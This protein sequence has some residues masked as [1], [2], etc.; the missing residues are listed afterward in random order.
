MQISD[1]N[2]IIDILN[3]YNEQ[4]SLVSFDVFDTL[5]RRDISPPERVKIPALKKLRELLKENDIKISIEQLLKTRKKIELNIGNNLL[6]RGFDWDCPIKQVMECML[7]E[8]QIKGD[9]KNLTNELISVE[10][11]AEESI[12]YPEPGM[13]EIVKH[14][15]RLKK[16]LIWISD[17]YL[18]KVHITSLL[19]KCGY[20]NFFYDGYVSSEVKKRKKTGRLY[21]FVLNRL[22]VAPSEWLHFGDNREADYLIP[23][24]LG[25]KSYHYWPHNHEKY[26][27]KINKFE[28]LSK[29]RPYW[30]GSSVMAILQKKFDEKYKKKRL[31]NLAY[32]SGFNLLAPLFIN[33]IHHV[34]ERVNNE[35]IELVLFPAREGFILQNIFEK[36][37]PYLAKNQNITST[38]CYLTRK[39]TFNA[40]IENIGKRELK[41]GFAHTN[42][43]SIKIMLNRF[44]IP[45]DSIKK[46]L[47]DCNIS[48]IERVIK[49]P[50]N[51][52]EVQKLINNKD[53]L[54]IINKNSFK[55]KTILEKYLDQLNFWQSKKVAIVDV[56][57]QGTVQDALTRTFAGHKDW[58]HL[59][60]LYMSFLGSDHHMENTFSTYEGLLY[61][62]RQEIYHNIAFFKFIQLFEIATRAPHGTAI[63]L[64]EDDKTKKIIP[65][66][67]SEDDK[68]RL[69]ELEDNLLITSIQAGI[70]DCVSEIEKIIPFLHGS[71]SQFTPFVIRNINR[72]IQLPTFKEGLLFN[73][74]V[75]IEDFGN[76][77][78]LKN[79]Q[80]RLCSLKNPNI[81]WK[82]GFVSSKKIPFL[83]FFYNLYKLIRYRM[84]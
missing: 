22:Q 10:I 60:G 35:N 13:I 12:V 65:I 38:Y 83:L 64:S 46:I 18:T 66:I 57:W 75:N 28:K 70:F 29:I 16:K 84:F 47:I 23:R 37:K 43:P 61:D 71:A 63:G 45:I 2:Q 7:N 59:F 78:I 52:Q 6:D 68:A 49:S 31:T 74:F 21:D 20:S 54:K 32:E 77:N 80:L 81:L 15:I 36:L 17:M 50:L 3:Q 67:K 11:N 25:G 79:K 44:G 1:P 82:E 33:F 56:G 4:T 76:D 19:K 53:F 9:I 40:S 34:I 41:K 27:L 48:S 42:K 73:Q 58:P 14:A 5:L 51:D 69:L 55:H 72:F 62:R 39:T 26:L 8:F 24:K 30:T